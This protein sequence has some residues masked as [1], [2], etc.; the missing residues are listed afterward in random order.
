[1]DR[2]PLDSIE[3]NLLEL[4]QAERAGVFRPTMISATELVHARPKL[5]RAQWAIRLSPIAAAVV[6]AIGVTVGMFQWQIN[7]LRQRASQS[8]TYFTQ[9]DS[10]CEGDF[11][12]CFTGPQDRI[13]IACKPFDFDSDGHVDLS[14]YGKYLADCDGPVATR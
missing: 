3:R 8:T 13:S 5:T 14:D 1:M 4:E 6:L 10:P 7:H 11:L 9:N 2:E 12:Q